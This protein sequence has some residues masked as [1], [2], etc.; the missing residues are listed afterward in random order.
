MKLWEEH[1][2]FDTCCR[3]YWLLLLLESYFDQEN[4]I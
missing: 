2:C 1:L 4:N 3:L